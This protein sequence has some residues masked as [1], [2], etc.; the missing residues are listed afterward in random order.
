MATTRLLHASDLHFRIAG[1]GETEDAIDPEQL[2]DDIFEMAGKQKFQPD[3]VVV[4]GDFT[5]RA[6]YEEFSLANKFITRVCERFNLSNDR[7]S[8][9][10]VPGN[11]DVNW[12]A[13]RVSRARGFRDYDQF[14][15]WLRPSQKPDDRCWFTCTWRSDDVFIL[16]LNSCIVESEDYAGMGYVDPD[17]LADAAK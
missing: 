1:A 10:V 7:S 17:Q 8:I 3:C 6:S 2:A 13:S 14:F 12:E 16:G 4:S 5:S 11:H 15:Q 9:V